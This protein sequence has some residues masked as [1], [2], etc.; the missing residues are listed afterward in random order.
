MSAVKNH[1]VA[2][3]EHTGTHP[4]LGEE[5]TI[6]INLHMGPY[7]YCEFDVDDIDTMQV[8]SECRL[9]PRPR[10]Q[11]WYWNASTEAFQDTPP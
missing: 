9:R 2:K 10:D 7:G 1:V 4:R 11:D 3:Q 6:P 5:Q 8:S